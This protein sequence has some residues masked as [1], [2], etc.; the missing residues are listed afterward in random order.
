MTDVDCT[1]GTCGVTQLD[2]A[3]L[4]QFSRHF[5]IEVQEPTFPSVASLYGTAHKC[6]ADPLFTIA[7]L[8]VRAAELACNPL[9]RV[10]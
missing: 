8:G 4:H 7:R 9:A 2:H 10:S 1:R 5:G 6:R 3:L